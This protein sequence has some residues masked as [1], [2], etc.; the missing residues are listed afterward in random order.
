MIDKSATRYFIVPYSYFIEL[1]KRAKMER[2]YKISER[3]R[4]GDVIDYFFREKFQ[5]NE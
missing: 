4:D 2:N 1:K 5:Y 3:L